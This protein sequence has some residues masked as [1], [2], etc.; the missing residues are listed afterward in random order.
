MELKVYSPQTNPRI[1]YVLNVVLSNL[2]GIE[3]RLTS[4][5]EE[6]LSW[7]G[8]ALSY[9]SEPVGRG[10][11]IWSEGLLLEK[12]L[13]SLKP[14]FERRQEMDVLFPAPEGYH[15]PFDLFSAAFYLISRY[16][17]YQGFT[18][19]A[20]NRFPATAS[21]LY[22]AGLLER[23]LVNEWAIALMRVLKQSYPQLEIHPRR[24]EY[25]SSL[26]IDQAWKY[27]NK[28]WLRNLGGYVRDL[29]KGNTTLLQERYDVMSGNCPD[30]YFN[31]DWQFEL[32][33]QYPDTRI[34]YF[35]LLARRAKFDKNISHTNE[36][37]IRLLEDLSKRYELG[38]HPS[39]RSNASPALI[40]KEKN[41][42]KAITGKEVH[43]SRQHFLMHR[44]PETYRHLLA[45]GIN[46]DHTMGY[47]THMGFRA[48]IAAPFPFYDLLR[49]EETSL[50]LYPFCVMDITALHYEQ[51]QPEEAIVRHR[52]MVDRVKTV[53]GLFVSL[54]HNESLSENERWKG[55]RGVYEDLFLYGSAANELHAGYR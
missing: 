45:L 18:P 53:G 29:M 39:Y 27:L 3:W 43:V 44:M 10:V 54:W 33:Q 23:P 52:Q 21:N 20:H 34:Q 35:I 42:L 41:R 2:C 37:F 38:I 12:G 14:K 47:S 15:L 28:G 49:E 13:Q 36:G 4:N 26:D 22:E 16:E 31:F 1:K 51:I 5:L 50:I 46:E 32:H 25:I 17:E 55:W 48:G 6:Y 8:P 9:H 19:D 40:K 7:N 11:F 24:F 30:P